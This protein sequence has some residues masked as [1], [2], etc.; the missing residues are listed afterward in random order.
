M[1]HLIIGNGNYLN[2]RKI[3]RIYTNN[4]IKE[5]V[6]LLSNIIKNNLNINRT[7]QHKFNAINRITVYASKYDI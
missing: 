1:A 7:R 3:T 2:D 4:L 5:D 6:I